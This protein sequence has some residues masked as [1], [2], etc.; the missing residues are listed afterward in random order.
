MTQHHPEP[1]P[2]TPA[3]RYQDPASSLNLSSRPNPNRHGRT[4]GSPLIHTTKQTH[5]TKA[6]LY[7][8]T[9]LP[10]NSARNM[11]DSP[12]RYPQPHCPVIHVHI[13]VLHRNI[14]ALHPGIYKRIPALQHIPVFHLHIPVS[15]QYP[16]SIS[17]PL[18]RYP[19]CVTVYVQ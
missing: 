19:R 1:S 8:A 17:R 5:Y 2:T 9:P 16:A 14:P 7:A 18:T 11:Q 12:R 10:V 6:P 13:L 15:S 3:V 4:C